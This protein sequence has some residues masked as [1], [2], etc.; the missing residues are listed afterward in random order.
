MILLNMAWAW[1]GPV[2][3]RVPF[4]TRRMY[5]QPD[6]VCLSLEGYPPIRPVVV[7]D[8]RFEATCRTEGGALR[9]C[10]TLLTPEWPKRV[11]PLECGGENLIRLRPVPAFDPQENI[12]DGVRIARGANLV[13]ATFRADGVPDAPGIL[14]GGSCGIHDE[15][16]WVKTGVE[17]KH[18]SCLLVLPT[19][20]VEVPVRLVDRVKPL[21]T[22]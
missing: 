12:W 8:G 10:L 9:L 11:A 15:Q 4:P 6:Q 13:Q 1:A 7:D 17:T 22:R 5:E 21:K 3:V 18:Q 2:T 16:L 19:G 20:E 14:P